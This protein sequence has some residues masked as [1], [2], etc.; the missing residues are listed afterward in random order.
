ME[1]IVVDSWM[2]AASVVLPGFV[3]VAAQPERRALDQ[4]RT[5]DLYK[6]G[7]LPG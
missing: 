5:P 2:K 7:L 4:T 6:P 3:A 1:E